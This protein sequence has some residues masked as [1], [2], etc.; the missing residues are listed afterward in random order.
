MVGLLSFL[1]LLPFNLLLF[2]I[3]YHPS[4][5]LLFLVSL[6]WFFA[7]KYWILLIFWNIIL[8]FFYVQSYYIAYC[9]VSESSIYCIVYIVHL[10]IFYFSSL[11]SLIQLHYI[12]SCY[13][14]ISCFASLM[15]LLKL[16]ICFIYYMYYATYF[17]IVYSILH[18][19]FY[20]LIC[21][22]PFLIFH[23]AYSVILF[24]F[25]SLFSAN[26]F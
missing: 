9:P 14:L 7:Y 23:Y 17:Y 6:F 13:F 11:L 4:S 21:L 10:L 3:L 2:Y 25:S 22:L 24:C 8:P 5:V 16:C 19:I 15:S 1:I 26:Y 18:L 12:D 20:M